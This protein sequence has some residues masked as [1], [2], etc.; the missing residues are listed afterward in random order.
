MDVNEVVNAKV[1]SAYVDNLPA[2]STQYLGPILFPPKK[3][4]GLDLTQIIGNSQQPISLRPTTFDAKPNIRSRIGG[5][6]LQ[7]EMPFFREGIPIF[8]K[9]RQELNRAADMNDP[10]ITAV[11]EN[12]FDDA[13]KLIRGAD[14]VPERMIMQLLSPEY[15][16][17]EINIAA[18]GVVYSFNYSPDGSFKKK[19]WKGLSGTSA[20]TDHTNSNPLHDIEQAKR[21]LAKMG[22]TPDAMILSSKTMTDIVENEK[23]RPYIISQAAPGAGVVFLTNEL[24]KKFIQ[25]NYKITVLERDLTFTDENGDSKAFFPDD[26]VT[27]IQ[28]K[29]LGTTRYG[30]TPEESDLKSKRDVD[31]KIVHT[32]V[33]VC[34]STEAGPPVLTKIWASQ[35]VMP[36]FEHLGDIFV[37]NTNTKIEP[38]TVTSA[39]GSESGKT[40][41]T[42]SPMIEPGHTYKYKT[43][44]SVT[45]PAYGDKISGGY[46][47]WNGVDEITATTDQTILIVEVD[48]DGLAVKCGTAK[49]K[50][51]AAV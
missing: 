28:L 49:I 46:S 43:G 25:Q 27:F 47:N 13:N 12:I 35:I 1:I 2:E 8:E 10:Y 26:I 34:T 14:V 51:K 9:D 3:Q 22:H 15:G 17:P 50:S 31:V 44:A 29:Q 33:A 48:A 42:V 40:A 7:N 23:I 18:D 6:K 30:T 32:G 41:I 37:L 5:L 24:V 36:S 39:E 11:L 19:N 4:N 45:A 38:I 20:W 21:T 16:E